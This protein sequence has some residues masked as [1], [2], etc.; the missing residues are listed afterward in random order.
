MKGETD[1]I[2]QQTAQPLSVQH[3]LYVLAD[4]IH[5][6]DKVEL[7][8]LW[9]LCIALCSLVLSSEATEQGQMVPGAFEADDQQPTDLGP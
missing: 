5:N 2:C 7:Y 6:K 9:M 8:Y 1:S 3:F 4:N